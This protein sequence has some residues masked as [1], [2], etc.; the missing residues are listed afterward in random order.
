MITHVKGTCIIIDLSHFHCNTGH[1]I[2]STIPSSVFL[3]DYISS[4]DD[5]QRLF[6]QRGEVRSTNASHYRT[7]PTGLIQPMA[8]GK[9]GV[10]PSVKVK[11][12]LEN[13]SRLQI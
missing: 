11:D 3:Y 1:G 10:P 9:Q 7:C 5:E 13:D 6:L 12:G 4:S 8:A 2:S